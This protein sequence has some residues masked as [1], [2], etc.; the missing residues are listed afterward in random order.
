MSGNDRVKA[1]LDEK[2]RG[3]QQ[4]GFKTILKAWIKA[5]CPKK[6]A[7]FP[8]KEHNGKIPGWWPLS[9]CRYL[10]PDH[11]NKIG[12]SW[13]RTGLNAIDH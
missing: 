8:Y 10:E 9:G 11:I 1:A 2:A 7:K 6:Q 13:P 4:L 3:I 5:I 12:T